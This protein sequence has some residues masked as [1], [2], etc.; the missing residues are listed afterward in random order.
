M[1]YTFTRSDSPPS[2]KIYW[3]GFILLT[4]FLLLLA[5]GLEHWVIALVPLLSLAAAFLLFNLQVTI[6][7]LIL[8][9]F[10]GYMPFPYFGARIADFVVFALIIGHFI[11]RAIEGKRPLSGTPLDKAIIPLLGIVAISLINAVDFQKGMINLLRHVELFLL[12]Y[13]LVTE[14]KKEHIEQYLRFYVAMVSFQSVIAIYQFLSSG[15][16]VRAFGTAGVPF[17]QLLVAALVICYVYCLLHPKVFN[18]YLFL[19]FLM[20]GALIATQTRSSWFY[21]ALSF[22]I[23]SFLVFLKK[24]RVSILKRAATILTMLILS[25]LL[26][27]AAFPD[28]TYSLLFRLEQ[29]SFDVGT[30]YW[31]VL[32]WKTALKIFAQHP[33]MGIGLAQFPVLSISYFGLEARSIHEVVEGLTAH[34]LLLSYLAETGLLGGICLVFFALSFLSLGFFIYRRVKDPHD[35][36]VGIILFGLL[37]FEVISQGDWFRSTLGMAFMF[38]L[39]LA[40]VF[41]KHLTEVK[42]ETLYHHSQF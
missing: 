35:I 1:E 30:L 42:D 32:L 21:F 22:F 16:E 7:A 29:M 4:E 10:I 36:P 27:V 24:R 8:T 40:V 17:A 3:I 12:F 39:A 15:G 23:V 11:R 2:L 9:L 37:I 6:Y 14:V 18:R 31:R 5:V 34:S 25:V 41:W 13:V 19:F 33:I 38:I 28:L 26:L 20:I